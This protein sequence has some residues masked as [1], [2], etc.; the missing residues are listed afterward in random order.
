MIPAS[1]DLGLLLRFALFVA[2]VNKVYLGLYNR[3]MVPSDTMP[4][5]KRDP[6][7]YRLETADV[8]AMRIMATIARSGA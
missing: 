2:F 6:S 8:M 1:L 3:C 7:G 4:Q 5:Q